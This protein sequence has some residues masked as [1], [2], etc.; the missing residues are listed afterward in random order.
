MTV[1]DEKRGQFWHQCYRLVSLALSMIFGVVGIVF[2]VI[3]TQV[4]D[5]FNDIS[6][7][8]GMPESPAQGA[9]FFLILAVAYMY[10]VSMLAYMMYRNPENSS[11]PLLLIS[12][13][14]ASSIVSILFI[15]VHGHILIY[16]VNAITDGSIAL[17]VF[18]LNRNIRGRS[19]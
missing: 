11:Y 4:L 8:L 18:L 7:R 15:I 2:M 5:L 6:L 9:S 16:M 1:H 19:L 3:P 13:K 17:G 14:A 10:L 12:G